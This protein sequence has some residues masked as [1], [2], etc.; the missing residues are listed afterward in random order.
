[1]H[2]LLLSILEYA[3]I[4]T[5]PGRGLASQRTHLMTP[6]GIVF[7]SAP[8]SQDE[9]IEVALCPGIPPDSGPEQ[10]HVGRRESPGA[11]ALAETLDKFL[12]DMSESLDV[13]RSQVLTIQAVE[14]SS[15][16][17]VGVY[18]ALP[19]K[20]FQRLADALLRAMSH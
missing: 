14:T 3:C 12:A 16:G 6:A 10:G 9:K 7:G 2:Q 13:W 15:P 11:D 1:M 18:H 20:A 8:R 17:R 4:I 19:A 5:S